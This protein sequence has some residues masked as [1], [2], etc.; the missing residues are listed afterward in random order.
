MKRP[1]TLFIAGAI[2]AATTAACGEAGVFDGAGEWTRAFVQG[3]TTTTVELPSIDAG[4]SGEAAVGAADVV[5]Y[6][7]QKD[8][9]HR[10]EPAQ[11]IADVWNTRIG[12]SR[13]VQASRGE[14]ADALPA[15][16]FPSL[17]P[18]QVRWVTSQL[19]YDETTAT[20]DPN[21]SAAFGLWTTE[22]YQSDTGR[23]GVLR[24]GVAASETASQ[25]GEITPIAVPDGIS[26]GWTD[27]SM[28]YELFCRT[29]ISQQLC[30]EIAESV[31]P[32]SELLVR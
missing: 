11:V 28:R 3:D 16:K 21:T 32:L 8:P 20:L 6:N 10:G 18:R 25:Q 1:V 24:V 4:V 13:F 30:I 26:L 15:L 23:I 31:K 27:T 22:P 19:V 29:E 17:V 7:D 14:I 5:W 2:V 12:N 9:Q